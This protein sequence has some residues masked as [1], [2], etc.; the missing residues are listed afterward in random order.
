MNEISVEELNECFLNT[1]QRV[2]THLLSENDETLEYELFEEFD[3]NAITFLH[4]DSLDPLLKEG[5]INNKIKELSLELRTKSSKLLQI[6]DERLAKF[7][8][9]NP[10]W[11]EVFELADQISNII[12]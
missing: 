10:K 8:R 7:V 4:T 9:S 6:E 11:R 3:I 12:N 1:I 5:F 2:G